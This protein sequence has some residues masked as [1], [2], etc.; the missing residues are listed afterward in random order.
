MICTEQTRILRLGEHALLELAQP[1]RDRRS[2]PLT[3]AERR[4]GRLARMVAVCLVPPVVPGHNP[5]RRR[6]A[7]FGNVH[8]VFGKLAQALT[9]ALASHRQRDA[10]CEQ[11]Y[12]QRAHVDE[13]DRDAVG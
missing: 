3:P 4:V 10:Q 11:D 12:E 1:P 9:K 8:E 7:P 2:Q 6:L 13:D 5:A